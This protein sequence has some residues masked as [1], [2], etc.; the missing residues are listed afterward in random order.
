MGVSE[1]AHDCFIITP[2][3]SDNS[4]IRRSAEGVIESVLKPVLEDES[5]FNFHV[6]VA[7][8]ISEGG[9]INNQVLTHILQDKLV[10]ANLTGLNANVM[11]ELA[12]RHA[13]RKPVVHICEKGT[14]LPFDLKDERTLFYSN[15]M[16]GVVEL[17]NRFRS[18]VEAALSDAT[19]D[20]PIY[21]A[22]T[23]EKVMQEISVSEPNK[24]LEAALLERVEGIE[25]TLKRLANTNMMSTNDMESTQFVKYRVVLIVQTSVKFS[26]ILKQFYTQM[27]ESFLDF[28]DFMARGTTSQTFELARFT[29]EEM[30]SSFVAGDTLVFLMHFHR[31]ADI[32][33]KSLQK[34]LNDLAKDMFTVKFVRRVD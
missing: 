32:S 19:P 25:N 31:R 1:T 30:E 18:V 23:L 21:R 7:H 11:Y 26:E 24:Y 13:A 16:M 34:I 28:T 6:V 33:A 17:K 29:A 27:P 10:I 22:A 9:S 12:V 2:I 14:T 5:H 4:E 3:G 20:N 15:D 8:T